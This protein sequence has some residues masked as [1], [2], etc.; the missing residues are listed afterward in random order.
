MNLKQVLCLFESL[1]LFQPWFMEK[2]SSMAKDLSDMVQVLNPPERL[3]PG[4]DFR[5]VLA[6]CR[7]WIRINEGKGFPAFLAYVR[8]RAQEDPHIY[9]IRGMIRS[10]GKAVEEDEKAGALK[11]HLTL[12]LAEELEQEE[13]SMETLLKALGGLE[14]PLKGALEE[15]DL[16]GLLSD[17]PG[18]E[19]ETYFTEERSGRVLDAWLSLYGEKV[20]AGNPL[21][22]VKP[23]VMQYIAETW[24]EFFL[25][26]Q[27]SGLPGFTF[28]YPDLSVLDTEEFL[29]RRE[30]V[31]TGS[32]LGE[33]M[34]AFCR[35]PGMGFPSPESS[36]DG[37]AK[38]AGGLKWTF[39]YL[40][41]GGKGRFPGRYEFMKGLSGKIV[42]LVQDAA[43]N[44]Q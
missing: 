16:P 31:L 1:I 39:V 44:E 11:G 29:K 26:G 28:L 8:N 43:P 10:T 34:A 30:T 6:E 41:P 35:D 36:A 27:G 33:A 14:S 23:R 18:V 37:P 15:E 22:T 38:A 12:H 24:E 40:P 19:R 42:G 3:K 21:V 32:G 2:P 25:Q 13:E 5:S 20:P 7:Q 4:E 9:E 17:L